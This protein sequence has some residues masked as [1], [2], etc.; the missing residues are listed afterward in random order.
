MGKRKMARTQI[1]LLQYLHRFPHA[2]QL[3]GCEE[4]LAAAALERRGLVRQPKYGW[5]ELT[6]AGRTKVREL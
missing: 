4:F 3:T 5:A 1:E 6:D 2:A